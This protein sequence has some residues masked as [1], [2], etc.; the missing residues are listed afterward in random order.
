MKLTISLDH[1]LL[2]PYSRVSERMLKKYE[3]EELMETF[4][5]PTK[6]FNQVSLGEAI[7]VIGSGGFCKVKQ[8]INICLYPEADEISTQDPFFTALA[9]VILKFRLKV[10]LE[11]QVHGDFFCKVE[12][13]YYYPKW[14]RILA[15]WTLSRADKIR[16]A[17]E[18]VGESLKDLGFKNIYIQSV[19]I[20]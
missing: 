14:R 15:K 2:D 20:C 8:F 13:E 19:K 4:I 12:G 1:K 6:K 7:E 3:G 18:R 9:G 11:I 17:G 5:I 10:P 16:V